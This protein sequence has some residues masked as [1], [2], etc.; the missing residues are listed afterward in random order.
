MIFK[1]ISCSYNR[2]PPKVG[3]EP[4]LPEE[5]QPVG[6]KHEEQGKDASKER[7]FAPAPARQPWPR[8]SWT[9]FTTF[10]GG[11]RNWPPRTTGTWPWPTRCGTGCCT[12]GCKPSRPSQGRRQGGELS[13]GGIPAGAAPGQQ[14]DQP[15]HLGAGQGSRGASLA[16]T[17][18]TCWSRRRS[19]GW[20]TAAWAAGGLLPGFAGHAAR[21]RPSATASATSSA[22]STRRSGTA[23][24]WR[25]PTSGCDCGNPWE[26]APARD[27]LSR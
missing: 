9:T 15:G 2:P 1:F 12:T 27:R 20:A 16:S 4:I 18:T 3:S 24:R 22:S 10:R 21:S 8:P 23:G 17:W 7:T 13:V 6:E 5:N 11:P 14:P 26:I 25:S 19:P